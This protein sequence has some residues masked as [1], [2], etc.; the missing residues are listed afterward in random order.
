M[1]SLLWIPVLL[2]LGC[3]PLACGPGDSNP[4]NPVAPTPTSTFSFTPTGSFTYTDTA[5]RT[6]TASPTQTHTPTVTPT[7][8]SV[9]NITYGGFDNYSP[10]SVTIRAGGTVNWDSS[11]GVNHTLYI[12][13][14]NNSTCS[15]NDPAHTYPFSLVFSS[16]G[17]YKYH[18]S[19]HTPSCGTS[20]SGCTGG[21]V[22]TV[23]VVP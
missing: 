15:S 5:T 19:I 22:G 4:N 17:T 23:V 21:M 2:F 3:L 18:C 12:D 9:A 11:F 7:P 6:P 1:K 10:A 20:C 16:A 13:T 8:P 14:G